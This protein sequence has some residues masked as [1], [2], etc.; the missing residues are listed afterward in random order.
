MVVEEAEADFV[1]SVVVVIAVFVACVSVVTN[2]VLV[3]VI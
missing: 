1:L 3:N 2:A